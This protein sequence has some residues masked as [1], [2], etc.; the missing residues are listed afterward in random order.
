M[1]VGKI[2]EV[3]YRDDTQGRHKTFEYLGHEHGLLSFRNTYNNKKEE[4]PIHNIIR[5]EEEKKGCQKRIK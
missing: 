4:I 3:Y 1:E 2:Y 5:I